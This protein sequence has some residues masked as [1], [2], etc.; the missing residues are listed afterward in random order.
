MFDQIRRVTPSPQAQFEK[1][2]LPITSIFDEKQAKNG[3][4]SKLPDCKKF[5]DELFNINM[6]TV[7]LYCPAQ[8]KV[9]VE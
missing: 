6:L 4:K 7:D 3:H 2:F 5:V 8:K 1:E 9:L